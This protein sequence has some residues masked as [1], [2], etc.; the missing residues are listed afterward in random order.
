MIM[1]RFIVGIVLM[2]LGIFAGLYVGGWLLF[3][4]GISD[5]IDAFQAETISGSAVG[6]GAFK[7]F[8]ANIVGWLTFYIVSV[9][10][11]GFITSDVPS[12]HKGRRRRL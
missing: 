11:F 3:V 10:G 12:Y 5:V 9:V 7:I 2:L 4:G 6:I 8:I 1:V